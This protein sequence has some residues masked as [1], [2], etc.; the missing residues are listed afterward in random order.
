MEGYGRIDPVEI[1]P[2]EQIW[3]ALRNDPVVEIQGNHF[4]LLI[5]GCVQKDLDKAVVVF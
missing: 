2:M 1:K 5:N 3:E 4:A